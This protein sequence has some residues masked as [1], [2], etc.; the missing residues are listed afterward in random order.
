MPR[1]GYT[2]LATVRLCHEPHVATALADDFVAVAP[3]EQRCQAFTG[4]GARQ[5]HAVMSS[6]RTR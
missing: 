5:A 6:S 2:V 3:P 4:D 1:D